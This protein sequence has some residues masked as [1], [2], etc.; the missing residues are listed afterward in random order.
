MPRV[1]SPIPFFTDHNVPDSVGRALTEAGHRVVRLREV[2][3]KQSPDQ[4]I[5]VAC[6]RNGH[7]LV[8]HDNDFKQ[9]SKQLSISK[10][11]YRN[12]L[13]RIHLRCPEPESAQR[14]RDALT[15]IEAEWVYPR[16][17]TPMV[18]EIA[19]HSIRVLR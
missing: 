3:D 4:V 15:L 17:D 1:N 11:Q 8:H 10:R 13:H 9:L 7:V 18:I 14:I 2:M 19:S 6:S 5:L 16:M 12:S